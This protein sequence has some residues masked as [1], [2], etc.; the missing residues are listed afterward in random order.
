MGFSGDVCA[1]YF[2]LADE[3]QEA[4]EVVINSSLPCMYPEEMADQYDLHERNGNLEAEDEAP[5]RQQ[6]ENWQPPSV[7]EVHMDIST[8]IRIMDP[9]PKQVPK[10]QYFKQSNNL[11]PTHVMV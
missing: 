8:C 3:E 11:F 1:L 2:H 9:S 5:M 6:K 10:D 7:W 4:M